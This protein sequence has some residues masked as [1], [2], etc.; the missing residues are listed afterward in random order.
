M[1][2][3]K[4]R[5]IPAVLMAL[6][7]AVGLAT[8]GVGGPDMIVK[9]AMTTASDML[10]SSDM[11]MRGKCN[12]CAGDEKGVAPATCSAICGA[13]ITA[14]LLAIVHDAIPAETLRPMAGARAI[15]RANP[16]DPY[17]PRPA[18]LS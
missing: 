14:P 7:L 2:F 16:P 18:V 11:S 9:S 13:M 3:D 8:H 15:G 12:G 5:R 17:P 6:V 1:S 4:I 10:T